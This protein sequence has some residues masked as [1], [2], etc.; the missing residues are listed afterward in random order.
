MTN[1]TTAPPPR[2]VDLT[3][4]QLCAAVSLCHQQDD[5]EGAIEFACR[6]ERLLHRFLRAQ[7]R[8]EFAAVDEARKLPGWCD[9]CASLP[10]RCADVKPFKDVRPF[11]CCDDDDECAACKSQRLED[12][13]AEHCWSYLPESHS[14]DCPLRTE[15]VGAN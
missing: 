11:T 12:S 7:E 9:E 6:L 3:V 13:C 2:N 1:K 10:C 4:N 5:F 15:S 8:A 14:P